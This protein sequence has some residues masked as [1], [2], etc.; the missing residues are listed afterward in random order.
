MLQYNLAY[1]LFEGFISLTA[2]FFRVKSNE[3]RD[4]IGV[5]IASWQV[6]P[7]GCHCEGICRR[8]YFIR[9]F[10][11][12][13]NYYYFTDDAFRFI[14]VIPNNLLK[15]RLM[16]YTLLSVSNKSRFPHMNKPLPLQWRHRGPIASKIISLTSVF[17]TVYPGADQG[18]HQ[19]SASLAFVPGIHRRPVNSSHKWPVTRKMFPFD[20]VIMQKHCHLYKWVLGLS[21]LSLFRLCHGKNMYI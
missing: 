21:A 10:M 17:S 14:E 6:L 8:L 15:V 12:A 4:L 20:D 16:F 19:S 5:P 3:R 13:Q 9:A 18:K 2:I 7:I 1:R 11:P